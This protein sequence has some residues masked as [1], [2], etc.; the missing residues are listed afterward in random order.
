MCDISQRLMRIT[1]A[2]GAHVVMLSLGGGICA[3]LGVQGC[4]S[5]SIG[6]ACLGSQSPKKRFGHWRHQACYWTPHPTRVATKTLYL[7]C[8]SDAPDAL[9]KSHL[10]VLGDVPLADPWIRQQQWHKK[11]QA[12]LSE[13]SVLKRNVSMELPLRY[14]RVLGLEDHASSADNGMHAVPPLLS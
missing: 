6:P 7:N 10:S 5:Y 11:S 13:R 12:Y 8:C 3:Q 1:G 14:P 2:K 4:R 9:F